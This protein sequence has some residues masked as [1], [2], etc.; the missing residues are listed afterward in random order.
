MPYADSTS[1][2]YSP[3]KGLELTAYSVR[4]CVAPASSSS[5]GLAFGYNPFRRGSCEA[6]PSCLLLLIAFI[7]P[8]ESIV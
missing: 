4:S 7:E 5:S 1:P 3:N 6:N 2:T 8:L